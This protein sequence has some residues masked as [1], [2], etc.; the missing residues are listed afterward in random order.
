V[1]PVIVVVVPA[2]FTVWGTPLE[3]LLAKLPSP[4]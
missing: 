4:A 2:A 3:L 1:W